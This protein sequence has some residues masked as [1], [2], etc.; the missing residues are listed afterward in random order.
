MARKTRRMSVPGVP[1][2]R[3]GGKSRRHRKGGSS[4]S[5]G[6]SPAPYSDGASYVLSNY[7]NGNTQWDN[8][9]VTGSK[10]GN[11]IVNLNHPSMTQASVPQSGGKRRTKKGGYWGQV[12][13]Q[14]LVPFGLF[15]AQNK[16]SRRVRSNKN[17]S[18]KFRK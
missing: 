1:G 7:G 17:K 4:G 9:F 6:S 2:A 14:A 8:V 15:A 16:F 5:S 10:Y 11:E 18:R 12:L 3:S 13:S